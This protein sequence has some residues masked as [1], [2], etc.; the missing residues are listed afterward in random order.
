M[1]KAKIKDLDKLR[2]LLKGNILA[3]KLIDK[4]EFMEKT[5]KDLEKEVTDNGVITKMPQGEYS[6]DR[7]NPALQAYNTTI[8]NYTTII[9]Q[10]NDMIPVG[11]SGNND[12][13]EEF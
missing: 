10:L 12:G 13:F 6:I 9:K 3:L 7:A 2:E 1:A 5:L 11:D 8:K 4:A